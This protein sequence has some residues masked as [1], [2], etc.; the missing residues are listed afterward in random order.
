[1]V[2]SKKKDNPK[3]ALFFSGYEPHSFIL[4]NEFYIFQNFCSYISV[5]LWFSPYFHLDLYSFTLKHKRITGRENVHLRALPLGILLSDN[6]SISL[7]ISTTF[8][9]FRFYYPQIFSR[10][11]SGLLHPSLYLSSIF[12]YM[13]FLENCKIIRYIFQIFNI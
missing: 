2:I 4:K 7:A 11:Q 6:V 8:F 13:S 10:L 12:K 9:P 5:S 1:M 3:I